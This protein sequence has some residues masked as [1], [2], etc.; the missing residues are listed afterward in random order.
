[1]AAGAVRR[2]AAHPVR[3]AEAGRAPDRHRGHAQAWGPFDAPVSRR[4]PL[5]AIEENCGRMIDVDGESGTIPGMIPDTAPIDT[6]GEDLRAVE[7]IARARAEIK[8]EVEK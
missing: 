2:G 7:E 4:V 5:R 8:H 3:G 6:S 1:G